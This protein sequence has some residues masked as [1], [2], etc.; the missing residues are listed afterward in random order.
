MSELTRAEMLDLIKRNIQNFG[1]HAYVVVGR[2]VPRFAYTIG[3]RSKV[4]V[5]LILAGAFLYSGD[6]VKRILKAAKETLL[7]AGGMSD[8]RALQFEVGDLGT[9]FLRHVHPS[10][11]KLLLLGA[12]DFYEGADVDAVQIVPDEEHVTIDVP[13]LSNPWSAAAE[14]VWQWLGVPWPYS[15]PSTSVVTTNIAAL[16]RQPITEVCRW[17]EDE[18]E[19]FSGRG[20][21]VTEED[22]RVVPIGSLL[23]VDPSLAPALNLEIGRGIWRN[24][25]NEEWNAWP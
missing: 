23:A 10:W 16:R 20:P 2:V 5:E 15:V 13:D 7:A 9:F 14:P 12:I 8:G 4:G 1:Y 25:K 24:E 18:W 17:A 11:C 22:A 19:M 6:E 21:E 3:L